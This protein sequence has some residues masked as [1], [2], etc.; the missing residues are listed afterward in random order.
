[1]NSCAHYQIADIGLH[2]VPT[3]YKGE[4]VEGFH[5]LL[6]STLGEEPRF[7]DFVTNSDGK[8]LKIPTVLVHESIERLIRAWQQ[9]GGGPFGDWARRQDNAYLAALL[10]PE[11]AT[12]T[13]ES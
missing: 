2:G 7:A 1:L 11:A 10:Y 6:G 12:A 8:R 13:G 9:A 3:Q 4:K 5:V